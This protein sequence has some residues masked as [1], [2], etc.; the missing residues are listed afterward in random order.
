MTPDIQELK[1]RVSAVPANEMVAVYA[2]TMRGLIAIAEE[3]LALRQRTAMD[4]LLRMDGEMYDV[5][6]E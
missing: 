2:E 1:S 5:P 6:K 4:D 3:A